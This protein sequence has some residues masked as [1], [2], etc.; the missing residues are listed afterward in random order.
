MNYHLASPRH[1]TPNPT[2]SRPGRRLRIGSLLVFVAVISIVGLN[3]MHRT[4]TAQITAARSSHKVLAAAAPKPVLSVCAQNSATQ[5]IFVSIAQ[6]HAWVCDG[7][8]QVNDSAVTTGTTVIKNNVDD[9]TP[10]GTW[11]IQAKYTST[12]LKGSDANGSWDDFVQYWMPFDGEI[13]FHDASWQTFP[14]GSSQY[15][16]AGSHGCVHLP[17]AFIGWF[18][19]WAPVG[20][21]V[22]ITG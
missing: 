5:A 3:L 15:Q 8:R 4:P 11:Q 17:A 18:Y 20:T 21:T 9:R 1:A 22:V 6:Q 16:T 2:I 12:Y 10:T 13:G 7:T 19:N 14:F